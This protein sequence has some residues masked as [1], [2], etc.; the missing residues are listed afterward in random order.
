MTCSLRY[1]AFAFRCEKSVPSHAWLCSMVQVEPLEATDHEPAAICDSSGGV[2]RTVV[3]AG[4]VVPW[5]VGFGRPGSRTPAQC[6]SRN[7]AHHL[8]PP[9]P[10]SADAPQATAM[11]NV[12]V[13]NDDVAAAAESVIE[14]GHRHAGGL[15]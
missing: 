14:D 3:L 5:L 10:I 8:S 13:A 9:T 6:Q 12:A 1:C 7:A 15:G 2:V 11:G 4:W